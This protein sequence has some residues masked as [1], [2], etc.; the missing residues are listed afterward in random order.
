MFT[1]T[2]M[3]SGRLLQSGISGPRFRSQKPARFALAAALVERCRGDHAD[4]GAVSTRWQ[5]LRIDRVQAFR[6]AC[7]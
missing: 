2:S 4:E 1:G 5:D 6:I 3:I 7:N